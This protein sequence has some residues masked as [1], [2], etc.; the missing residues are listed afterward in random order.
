MN[1]SIALKSVNGFKALC[2]QDASTCAGWANIAAKTVFV[3]APDV[4]LTPQVQIA[5]PSQISSCQ[6]L[7]ID[8]TASSGNAGRPWSIGFQ[9]VSTP[10]NATNIAQLNRYFARSYQFSPPS[11]VPMNL[12][13]KG[14]TYTFTAT[15]E[16]F[17]GASSSNNLTTVVLQESANVP[18][19]TISGSDRVTIYR[20]FPMQIKSVA[21][22]V[23]C[24]GNISYSNLQ[25]AWGLIV[26]SGSVSQTFADALQS[27]TQSRNPSLYTL[28]AYTLP[29]SSSFRLNLVVTHAVSGIS[30]TTTATVTVLQGS[31]VAVISG[32][33]TQSIQLDVATT[34]D[35]STSYDQDKAG[36]TGRAAGLSYLWTCTQQLPVY[37]GDCSD[38]LSFVSTSSTSE[39]AV[40]VAN[41]VT[42]LLVTSQ[43]SMTVS[44][45]TRASTA[46]VY[47]KVVTSMVNSVIITTSPR[48]VTAL[49]TS[50]SLSIT[51][52]LIVYSQCD[53]KWSVSD[54]SLDL[55]TISAF[56]PTQSLSVGKQ[57]F[58][59]RLNPNTLPERANLLFTLTC[60]SGSSSITVTTNGS[61][62][63]GQYEVSPIEG[64]ELSTV[65]VFVASLWNDPDL[66]ITY[67][68][69][70]I[71]P[72][73]RQN[74]VILGRSPTTTASTT[75]PAGFDGDGNVVNCTLQVFDVLNST[76][77]MYDP[78]KVT[79]VTT[80]SDR[81]Q[82]L[83][84][85][86]S[87]A[88]SDNVDSQKN[89]IS[90]ASTTLNHINCTVPQNCS[91]INRQPCSKTAYTCGS[92]L[93][94][95]Q[96][97][98]GDKN[99][100]CISIQSFKNSTVIGGT[101]NSDAQCNQALQ[102]CEDGKC[103]FLS[104]R[105]PGDCSGNGR[106]KYRY[107][108]TGFSLKNCSISDLSCEALCSCNTG[109]TGADC[110]L[111]TE[112]IPQ[113]Q[114]ARSVLVNTLNNLTK[115]D[116]ITTES[117]PSWA[118]YL[119]SISVSPDQLALDDLA[120]VQ[121]IALTTVSAG[122]DLG[123]DPSKLTGI[124]TAID[125]VT[126]VQTKSNVTQASTMV[127]VLSSYGAMVSNGLIYGEDPATAIYTN[128]RISNSIS[129]L[130]V[131]S[132]AQAEVPKTDIETL[133]ESPKS[134]ISLIPNN[135]T[136]TANS[137]YSKASFSISLIQTFEKSYT[138][139]ADV[140][141]SDPIQLSLSSTHMNISELFN[142]NLLSFL[143]VKIQHNE[144]YGNFLFGNDTRQNFTSRCYEGVVNTTSFQCTYAPKTIYHHCNGSYDGYLL[145]YCPIV[146]PTCNRLNV[147]SAQIF[148][149]SSC[150]TMNSTKTETICSCPLSVPSDQNTTR[151][152]L[153]IEASKSKHEPILSEQGG[154]NLVAATE[155]LGSDFVHT[156]S[157]QSTLGGKDGAA[158]S[159]I[160]IGIIC[161][162]WGGGFLLLGIVNYREHREALEEKKKMKAELE[163]QKALNSNASTRTLMK[164]LKL[165][166]LKYIDLILPA[167]YNI[168]ETFF[169][170]TL[171][172]IRLHHRYFHLF[173][174]DTR[175]PNF[176][177]R[178]Y[179]TVKIL[180]V[181]TIQMFLQA[182]LFDLQNPE[183]DGTCPSHKDEATC[184]QRKTILDQTQSYCSWD[185]STNECSY[186]TPEFS[187]SAVIYV[188]IITAICTAM[189]KTPL[190]FLLKVWV[191]PVYEEVDL[192]QEMKV[193]PGAGISDLNENDL[194]DKL[195]ANNEQLIISPDLLKRAEQERNRKWI[196]YLGFRHWIFHLKRFWYRIFRRNEALTKNA[197]SFMNQHGRSIPKEIIKSRDS[198]LKN[199][200]VV[201]SYA[202]SE[203]ENEKPSS[204]KEKNASLVL[205]SS[206][207]LRDDVENAKSPS[208]NGN[209]E[210]PFINHLCED[211]LKY[212]ITLSDHIREKKQKV[213]GI[214]SNELPKEALTEPAQNTTDRRKRRAS[215]QLSKEQDRLLQLYED[216]WGIKE[217][218]DIPQF[219]S[220]HPTS[221]TDEF[222]E[223]FDNES[224]QAYL[225]FY[226]NSQ[227]SLRKLQPILIRSNSQTAGLELMNL[228]IVDILGNTTRS[229]R[230]FRNKFNED[231]E[232]MYLV[233]RIW[234][235]FCVFLVFAL[236]AFFLYYML[237]RGASK[238][239]DW[240]FQFLKVIISQFAI[241]IFLFET[242]ECVSLHYLIP[243]SVRMDVKKAV[244]ILQLIA[245]NIDTLII[246]MDH[247]V[248]E[249]THSTEALNRFDATNYFFISK[250]LAKL[251][252]ELL[253][254]YIINAYRN[255]FPGMICHTWSHY[256]KRY[257][258]HEHLLFAPVGAAEDEDSIVG[259]N[260]KKKPGAIEFS[261]I[262]HQRPQNEH[263]NANYFSFFNRSQTNGVP[264]GRSVYGTG[265][266]HEENGNE[267]DDDDLNENNS[268]RKSWVFILVSSLAAGIIFCLQAVGIMP[269]FSQRLIIRLLETSI[270][271]GL[272]ILWYTAKK[273]SS[274]YSIFAIVVVVVVLLFILRYSYRQ[275]AKA[276]IILNDEK[277]I[278]QMN[279]EEIQE[280]AEVIHKL[281]EEHHH[282]YHKE[283]DSLFLPAHEDLD[284][285]VDATEFQASKPIGYDSNE[286][287]QSVEEIPL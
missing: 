92:C 26:L 241:E 17:L 151:R 80:A 247:E 275:Q 259:N 185:G 98:S 73:T 264:N 131:D 238:G 203:Y 122:Q 25:Y 69:G 212:H 281:Q 119:N 116:D 174:V 237:L 235:Y 89:L 129:L 123:V 230:I 189:F 186:L 72:A 115:Q 191:C 97:D 239:L 261:S 252:P 201:E 273:Q 182:L 51:T 71:S 54:N 67:Q 283:E 19:V 27:T 265:S 20:R 190:D 108:S 176:S 242:I 166:I 141:Y 64:I 2:Q 94:N 125:G 181:Q 22:T 45:A 120:K 101:C 256:K 245:D 184:L 15:M 85:F 286:S 113:L 46:Y 79:P 183:D 249:V 31:L 47:I 233:T 60:G 148:S 32:S 36:V 162:V 225:R 121:E 58:N 196:P 105:C 61:P 195:A 55:S 44:D 274:Y 53:A 144:A 236:N 93:P 88:S 193:F 75:L 11:K 117:V 255:P 160:V 269:V 142:E 42:A 207:Q 287:P 206:Y 179:R 3:V 266:N 253:E 90:V 8:L 112:D 18:S 35:G 140:F 257:K 267:G 258:H 5:G 163:G 226:Q 10:T 167:V 262:S 99:S 284:H 143:I 24:S 271:S 70:F 188:M 270:L 208:K 86:I 77:T 220:S 157:A 146:I 68:F 209:N 278:D 197:Q 56:P 107:I 84:N 83:I 91:S 132:I 43:L 219:L 23:S 210:S 62:V 227:K 13:I 4:A 215:I 134:G 178:L 156:F 159:A 37:K 100:L 228:F 277:L 28:P 282:L 34:I 87:S 152:A 250:A 59:L 187:Q 29:A 38:V 81:K 175:R 63:P 285:V 96:G 74:L 126:T 130:S 14:T 49:S 154:A 76:Y 170:R 30:S 221:N 194:A 139:N 33:P 171:R 240:Q 243:E 180:S 280:E 137:S 102:R 114:R 9:I 133:I 263:A 248:N 95:F 66:P 158:K 224:L 246:S 276:D 65:F 251:R 127:G 110:L 223:G 198:T 161:F 128:F 217:H 244:R 155:Y 57:Q 164:P 7:S 153:K 254:T 260:S 211:V 118:N 21:Y 165:Q 234:K 138:K 199:F 1:S 39:K 50:N 272:T 205:G 16:N 104:K 103:V 6:P 135:E 106:C 12:L 192:P 213:L 124:L 222:R 218:L 231:Y 149:N 172:E 109:Y 177:D 202:K 268:Q 136:L 279:R 214:D 145:S 150:T 111:L 204:E 48:A 41:N 52:N 82:S 173:M 216:Q 229:A 78:V 168:Q 232:I 200:N 169:E 40:V 147:S